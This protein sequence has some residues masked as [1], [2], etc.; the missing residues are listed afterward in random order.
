MEV[1]VDKKEK[2]YIEV[3]L[4][5]EEHSFP[6]LL[7]EALIGMDD[8]EFAAY[9]INHPLVGK[10][11]LMIRTKNKNPLALLKTAVKNVKK[12]VSALQTAVK[13]LK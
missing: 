1:N 9:I 7:R 4:G 13:K 6:N 10:P 3:T 12:Y 8:V 2:N 5:G 11:K